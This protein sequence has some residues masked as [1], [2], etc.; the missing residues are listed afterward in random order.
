VTTP[1]D[2]EIV[3]RPT[4][5]IGRL[6]LRE[7]VR[8]RDVLQALG[9]RDIKLRYRQTALG[10]LWVVLQPLLAAGLLAFVFGQVAGLPADGGAP[11]FLFAF[12]GFLG[13]MLFAGSLSKLVPC[14]V[15][16]AQL[17]SKVYFPRVLIPVASMMST[18]LDFLVGA[19]LAVVLMLVAGVAP[20]SGVVS[21]PLW[22]ALIGLTA[23]GIGMA[24]AGAAVFFRDVTHILPVVTQLGL[25]AT[26][27]AYS[28]AAVPE[29][30]RT[31][32]QLNPLAPAIQGFRWSVLG[33]T[34]PPTWA[35]VYSGV[36]AL[37]CVGVG[38]LVFSRTERVF[39]DVI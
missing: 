9:V 3:L 38:A 36:F 35:I 14:L 25:Y 8:F 37:L 5:G 30:Y 10:V 16:N 26:P 19:A 7:A 33:G 4:S 20:S 6:H 39:A 2:V 23:F 27:V 34:A 1:T 21:L 11:Y 17:V 29:Q 18:M 15:N 13:W 32:F 24:G 31:F 28:L 22:T 12:V